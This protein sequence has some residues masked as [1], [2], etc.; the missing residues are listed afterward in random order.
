MNILITGS[1]GFVGKNLVDYLEAR[2]FDLTRLNLRDNI[3]E[4]T[5]DKRSYS[6]YIHL[7]GIAHDLNKKNKDNAYFEVN[8]ELTKKLYDCYLNDN[9]SKLFIF[10]SSI[11]V[12]SDQPRSRVTEDMH[13]RPK[14]AYGKSKLEAERYI[15]QHLPKDK[16][17]IILRPCMIHGPGNKGNLNSLIKLVRFN[18]PWVLAAFQNKRSYLSVENACYVIEKI[19]Y[20]K[21]MTSGIYNIADDMSLST[22]TLVK[23]IAE[24]LGKKPKL[25]QVPKWLISSASRFGDLLKLPVNSQVLNKLTGTYEVSN[26]KIKEELSIKN[27]PFSAEEGLYNTIMSF[28]ND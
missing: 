9:H 22:N 16:T 23:I 2:N 5:F 3:W 7:A 6:T 14:T 20:K 25:W 21:Q 1:S 24:A 15:M 11:K 28:K 19:L 10:F 8:Y 18:I 26:Q 4:S 17:V 12:V 27:L 13:P